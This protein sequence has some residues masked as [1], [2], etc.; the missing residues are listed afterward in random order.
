MVEACNSEDKADTWVTYVQ[1]V[2]AYVLYFAQTL[3]FKLIF[4]FSTDMSQENPKIP[5]WISSELLIFPWSK[6]VSR[7]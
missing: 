4:I 2:H 6:P 7:L 5:M 3:N 1:K